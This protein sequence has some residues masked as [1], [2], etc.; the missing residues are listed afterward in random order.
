MQVR[1]GV[2]ER[3]RLTQIPGKIYRLVPSSSGASV[4]VVVVV[5]VTVVVVGVVGAAGLDRTRSTLCP[6]DCSQS[7]GTVRLTSGLV[8]SP[9]HTVSTVQ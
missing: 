3:E 7:E 6:G 2:N 1:I 9:G 8:I 4:V 5:V